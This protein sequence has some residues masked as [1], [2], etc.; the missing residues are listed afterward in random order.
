MAASSLAWIACRSESPSTAKGERFYD[1]GEDFWPKRYAIWGGL[2]A[3]QPGQIAYSIIDAQGDGEFMPS[4]FPADQADSL[5]ELAAE[6]WN[7][8]RHGS[9]GC[10]LSTARSGPAHDPASLDD[11]RDRGLDP[12]KSHWAMP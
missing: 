7:S 6:A 12:P 8:I 10:R 2:I 11:C 1:E 5:A 3:R 9:H 4:V